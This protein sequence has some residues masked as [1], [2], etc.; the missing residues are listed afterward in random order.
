M[1]PLHGRGDRIVERDAL[2]KRSGEEQG[3]RQF[4]GR[5]EAGSFI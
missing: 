2:Q 3:G 1:G 4:V 5:R